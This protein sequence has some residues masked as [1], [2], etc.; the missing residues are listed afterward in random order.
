MIDSS[1]M[2]PAP[3]LKFCFVCH[4][5]LPC[6]TKC[7]AN[8]HLVLTPYDILCLKNR[9]NLSSEEFLDRYTDTYFEE[10]PWFP[11]VRLSMQENEA[12]QCPFVTPEGCKVY[13]ARP[14]AC[15]LYPLGRAASK[16]YGK[17]QAGEYYFKVKESHCLGW[18]KEKE[19][20]IQEWLTD[21]GLDEY[22]KMND[23]FMDI[24]TGRP[25]KFFKRLNDR[26]LQM[27]YMACYNLDAF[28]CFVF[29][30]TFLD[31][32]DIA[33]DV[34]NRIQT[35]EVELMVFACQ[36]LKFSLFGEKFRVYP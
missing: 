19:W 30:S 10:T 14:G 13:E 34:L 8:L 9:L 29:E 33:K 1:I 2:Q 4:K 7:C 27:Y 16:I 36:W 5:E 25:P 20:T 12:R 11:V 22:N 21:Q 35:D 17:H 24:T 6:F 23:F 31:R 26:Q 32:F 15:R 18:D 3:D 28:R